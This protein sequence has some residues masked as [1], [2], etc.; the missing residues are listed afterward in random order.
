MSFATLL[1]SS[2]DV[3]TL[4][5]TGTDAYNVPVRGVTD[6]ESYPC[7]LEQTDATEILV[8]RDTD[9]SNWLLFLPPDAVITPADQVVVDAVTYQ[10]VGEPDPVHG[11]NGVH[12][13][14]VRLR[15]VEP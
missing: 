4:G 12:H 8:G 14:E 6:S 15:R 11:L 7:R 5:A 13:F 2:A 1:D 3:L 10:V 9:V